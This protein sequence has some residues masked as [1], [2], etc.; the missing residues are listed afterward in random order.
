MSSFSVAPSALPAP[1]LPG[2]TISGS[3]SLRPRAEITL[4]AGEFESILLGQWLQGAESAFGSVPGSSDDAD[5]GDEQMKSFA[6][7]SLAKTFTASG[8]IGLARIVGDALQQTKSAGS[9]QQA[10]AERPSR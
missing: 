1:D 8:G 6:L 10:Q 2:S 4:A 5:P 3:T 7:Q 9:A